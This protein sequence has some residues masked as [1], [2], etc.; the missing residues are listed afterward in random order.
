VP[1]R[2]PFETRAKGA[3][4]RVTLTHFPPRSR[5]IFQHAGMDQLQA[6]RSRN[7]FAARLV[8]HACA[9]FLQNGFQRH[10]AFRASR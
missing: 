1:R 7:G 3:L 9:N 10:A 5:G 2:R 6:R 8:S 4:L